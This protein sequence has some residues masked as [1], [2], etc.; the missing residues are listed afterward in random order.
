[1]DNRRKLNQK[2]KKKV[3][4]FIIKVCVLLAVVLIALSSLIAGFRKL[5]GASSAEVSGDDVQVTSLADESV[6]EV[7][8]TEPQL[9]DDEM[10]DYISN[11]KDMYPKNLRKF[12]KTYPQ[13]L[14]FVYDYPEKKDLN[15]E[16]DLSQDYVEGEIPLLIQWDDRW[17]YASYGDGLIGTSGCGPTCLSMVYIGLT[18][19]TSLNPRRLCSFAQKNGYYEEGNGTSWNLMDEGAKKLGIRSEIIALGED[20]VKKQ[21]KKGHPL[22]LSVSEGEFTT[23]GHFIVLAGMEGDKFIVNDPNS[24]ENSERLWEWDE[25]SDQI[26]NLWAFSVSQD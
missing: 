5:R 2:G 17:G 18:R 23:S 3:V 16:I 26:K 22:I 6:P 11:N 8:N 20:E 24:R 14:K 4:V 19:D 10:M 21:L 7:E 1:M 12:C 15:P 9:S 13:T 25:F